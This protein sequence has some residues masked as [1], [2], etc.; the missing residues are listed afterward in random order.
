MLLCTSSIAH[1]LSA[2]ATVFFVTV[3][4]LTCQHLAGAVVCL[5]CTYQELPF[6]P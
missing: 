2:G 4:L 1:F 6:W 3:V 5:P